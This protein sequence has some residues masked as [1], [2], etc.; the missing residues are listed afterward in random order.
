MACTVLFYIRLLPFFIAVDVNGLEK[1]SWGVTKAKDHACLAEQSDLMRKYIS[2]GIAQRNQIEI[3][4][5][6]VQTYI[7]I[8]L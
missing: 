7:L 3:H 6:V 4:T 1:S 5:R 2:H 8:I